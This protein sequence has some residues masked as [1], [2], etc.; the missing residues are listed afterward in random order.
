[1]WSTESGDLRKQAAKKPRLRSLPPREQTAYLHRE[2]KGRGGK[3]VSLVKNLVL[4]EDDLKALAKE[5]K[6][7]CGSGGSVKDGVIIIQGDHRET[8]KQALE[9]LGYHAKIAGG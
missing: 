7:A 1:V 9:R 5:L 3:T 4:S 2:S 6:R 8:I